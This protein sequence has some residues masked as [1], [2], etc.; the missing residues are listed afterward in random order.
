MFLKGKAF[1]EVLEAKAERVKRAL[2]TTTMT[3]I[4]S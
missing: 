2:K 1:L 4:N 3:M